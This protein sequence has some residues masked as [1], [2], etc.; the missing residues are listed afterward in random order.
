[1]I[2]RLA[3]W[4]VL[5]AACGGE[6]PAI[7]PAPAPVGCGSASIAASSADP[8][9]AGRFT[10]G[11]RS[12]ELAGMMAEIWYPAAPGSE[13]GLQAKRY[14]LRPLL[15]ESERDK[16]SDADNPW[17][18]CSC[19]DGLPLDEG[20]GPYPIVMFLIQSGAA[21]SSSSSEPWHSRNGFPLPQGQ[22]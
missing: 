19:F 21:S 2:P 14:D 11:A 8:A 3:P 17:Q 16:I 13:T 4:I 15:P 7:A 6:E 12:V 5:V 1:M 18:I 9:A 22:G 20:S 10:V